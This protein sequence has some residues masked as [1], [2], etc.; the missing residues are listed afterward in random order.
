MWNRFS[1]KFQLVIF[2]SLIVITVEATTLFFI[3]NIQQK[4]NQQNAIAEAKAITQSLNNDLLKYF[5]NPNADMLSDITFRLSAFKNINGLIVYNDQKNPVFQ[6]SNIENIQKNAEQIY[7]QNNVFYENELLIKTPLSA[8][9][10]EFGYTLLEVDLTSF[11][12]KKASI[13]YTILA[14]FPFA[15]LFG[16]IM[17]IFISKSYTKPFLALID[18]MRKSE[19]TNNKIIQVSTTANNEIKELF[20]GFNTQMNQI[21][22]STKELQY[23]ATHDQLT[24]I[25]NRFY[26]DELISKTLKDSSLQNGNNIYLIDLDQFK[27]INDS[28]GNL[29]GDNLLKMIVTHYQQ[30]IPQNGILA[31]IDGDSFALLLKDTSKEFGEKFLQESLEQLRDFRFTHN[32]E[33]YSV[34]ASISL[35]FFKPF[36]FTL[37]ELLKASTVALYTAKQ[38]GRNKS[39]IYDPS[40]ESANRVSIEIETAKLIK[41]ALSNGP[42]RFELFAQDIVPLQ[43]ETDKIGYE[44]LIRMWDKDNNFIPPDN[45]LPTAERYQL[46]ADIDAYV[47]WTYLETVT[48]DKAHIEKLHSAHINLAGSSLNNPD[49]QAKVKE[50]IA[51][52]DFPWEKLELEVTESS[53]IGSFNMANEFIHF[54]KEKKIGLAL[55]DFGTGMASFEYLKSLPFDVVKIDGSFVKDMHTDP[56]DKAVIKYI[57]EIAELKGQETV[58]EYVETEDDVNELRNIGITYGQG[59]FLGKPRALSSWLES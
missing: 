11:N 19:P 13:T 55:D 58:A 43:Y 39:Q 20:D 14:I 44:I 45:F 38:K 47:L 1:I 49:F 29:A 46:M 33:T 10:Y 28:V 35:V 50:A 12:L 22:D 41:E 9:G 17:S 4:E 25:Y 56:T 59:Y 36:E 2:M 23:Q 30:I 31:R 54:L 15:L 51:H 40:D 52:F 42:S 5:L 48:K 34:S 26:M 18:S 37:N 7:S 32:N 57:Q 3:L 16:F 27:L 53:A 6:Y 24:G 21:A 8:D